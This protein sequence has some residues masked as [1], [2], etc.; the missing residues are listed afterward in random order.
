M[1]GLYAG[2]DIKNMQGKVVVEKIR[3]LKRKQPI[4]KENL[5]LTVTCG[6]DI[7]M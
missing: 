1:F 2:E 5:P 6:M 3:C 7:I 4:R